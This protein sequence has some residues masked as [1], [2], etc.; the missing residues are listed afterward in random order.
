MKLVQ[1][2]DFAKLAA[3]PTLSWNLTMRLTQAYPMYQVASPLARGMLDSLPDA[4]D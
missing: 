2:S 4:K 1:F 3:G